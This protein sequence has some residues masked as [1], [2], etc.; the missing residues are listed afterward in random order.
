MNFGRS[1]NVGSTVAKA[2]LPYGVLMV[3]QGVQSR[4]RKHM[5]TLCLPLNSAM[6]LKLKKS[7]QFKKKKTESSMPESTFEV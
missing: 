7:S 3:G 6:N 5:G 4:G 2:S 1:C